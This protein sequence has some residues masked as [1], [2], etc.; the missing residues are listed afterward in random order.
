MQVDSSCDG[1]AILEVGHYVKGVGRM[2]PHTLVFLLSFSFQFGHFVVS[3]S[4]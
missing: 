3:L 4:K 1:G 2:L